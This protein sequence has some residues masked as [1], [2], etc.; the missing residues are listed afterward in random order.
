MNRHIQSFI[1]HFNIIFFYHVV[2]QFEAHV[3]FFVMILKFLAWGVREVKTNGFSVNISKENLTFS[4]SFFL[5]RQSD[6]SIEPNI[7]SL[8]NIY[9]FNYTSQQELAHV[10]PFAMIPQF[11]I[12]NH[13]VYAGCETKL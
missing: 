11:G 12:L 2:Y 5:N 7:I 3:L 4:A 13:T 9:F 6:V 10:F 1:S 8:M